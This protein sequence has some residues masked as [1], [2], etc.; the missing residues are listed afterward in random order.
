M[1]CAALC[2]HNA[3]EAGHSWGI[4]LY[5]ITALPVSTYLFSLLGAD[6]KN[7]IAADTHWLGN[8]LDIIYFYP[9][10]FI[11]YFFFSLLIRIPVLNYLFTRTTMTHFPFWGRYREP[12]TKLRDIS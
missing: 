1:K 5:F 3:V 11:S 10:I 9:A 6:A 2:P 4:I 8:L 7:T 12:H